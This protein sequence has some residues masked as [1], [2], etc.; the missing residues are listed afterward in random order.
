MFP[1]IIFV[2]KEFNNEDNLSPRK[3]VSA[4]NPPV[5]IS[6]EKPYF[7]PPVTIS[8]ELGSYLNPPVT[9]SGEKP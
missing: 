7:L 5:T 3:N 8:G 4:L 9:I 2:V 6:G 1:P